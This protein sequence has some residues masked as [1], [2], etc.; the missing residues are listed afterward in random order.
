MSTVPGGQLN[1]GVDTFGAGLGTIDWDTLESSE[2]N[3]CF[4]KGYSPPMNALD[5]YN[6]LQQS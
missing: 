3:G 2:S 4:G 6:H 1:G 5:V